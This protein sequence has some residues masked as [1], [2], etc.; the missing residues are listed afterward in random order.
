MAQTEGP[1]GQ[2]QATDPQLTNKT[3]AVTP[4]PKAETTT[5]L[6]VCEYDGKNYTLSK[7]KSTLVCKLYLLF[8][9]YNF[10]N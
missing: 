9:T 5:P 3:D 2:V 4:T 1:S 6:I 8:P 10:H 7:S